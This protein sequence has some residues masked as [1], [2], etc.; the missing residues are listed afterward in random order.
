MEINLISTW[1]FQNCGFKLKFYY[2]ALKRFYCRVLNE[3]DQ[4]IMPTL[5]ESQIFL[6]SSNNS[7]ILTKLNKFNSSE[8]FD[9]LV[10]K[11]IRNARISC[12]GLCVTVV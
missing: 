2:N 7:K 6:E 12:E 11:N 5:M 4:Q 9:L 1:E 3:K 10:S 8:K